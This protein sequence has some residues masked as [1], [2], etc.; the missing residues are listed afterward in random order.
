[1]LPAQ[2]EFMDI[3]FFYI[4]HVF[5]TYKTTIFEIKIN[6]YDIFNNSWK[7]KRWPVQFE[8][9]TKFKGEKLLLNWKIA[10]CCQ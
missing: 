7:S 4:S 9:E 2:E 8:V 10:F 5:I 6:F 1:M 3:F